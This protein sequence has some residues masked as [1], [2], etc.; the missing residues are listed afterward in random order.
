MLILLSFRYNNSVQRQPSIIEHQTAQFASEWETMVNRGSWT[1]FPRQAA[2]FREPTRDI[3]QSF[4]WKTVVPS[5]VDV[6]LHC[7]GLGY[8]ERHGNCV[9]DM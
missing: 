9:K 7:H 6:A 8:D 2:K 5:V 4:P 3:W 1:I